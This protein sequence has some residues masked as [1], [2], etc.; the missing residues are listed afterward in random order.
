ML[1]DLPRPHNLKCLTCCVQ[2]KK[3]GKAN[4]DALPPPIND[5]ITWVPI[6]QAQATAAGTVMIPVPELVCWEHL[7]VMSP[8]ATS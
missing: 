3:A 5:A 8:L 6:W 1:P 7:T 2:A 4:P